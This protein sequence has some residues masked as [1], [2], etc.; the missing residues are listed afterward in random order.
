MLGL[1]PFSKLPLFATCFV[2][3]LA[4]LLAPG[5]GGGGG[6]GSGSAI[7]PEG[8]CGP[9]DGCWFLCFEEYGANPVYDPGSQA[10][11]PCILYD[12]DAFG[13][14]IGDFIDS[15]GSD[16]YSVKPYY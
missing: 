11:Y 3:I 4:L 7:P 16:T 6:G 8:E 2:V 10:Y 9:R 15:A 5:C 1:K 13:N 14:N 12:P